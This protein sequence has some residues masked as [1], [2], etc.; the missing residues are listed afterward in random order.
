LRRA[1]D[2]IG[3]LKVLLSNYQAE[4]GRSS[5]GAVNVVIKNGTKQFHG[6]AFYVLR[7]EALNAKRLLFN[8]DGLERPPYRF[9]S[10]G[11]NIGGPI[12]AG[13]PRF[14]TA[15]S[16]FWSQDTRRAGP[17]PAWAA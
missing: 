6:G 9:T 12:K 16:S 13:G 7:N 17:P 3:E 1:I 11:Y 5:G 8:R 4:Y 2:A 15:C 14:K 10:P